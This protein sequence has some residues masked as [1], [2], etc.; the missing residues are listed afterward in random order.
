M[1]TIDIHEPDEIKRIFDLRN[2][3]YK[4]EPLDYG[5]YDLG[6]DVRVERKTLIDLQKSWLFDHNRLDNQLLN[7]LD[8]YPKSILLVEDCKLNFWVTK[9]GKRINPSYHMPTILKHV[10]HL[11]FKIPIVWSTNIYDTV[12][13]LI[14]LHKLALEDKHFI[15]KRPVTIPSIEAKDPHLL[16]LCGI[17]N[18]SEVKAKRILAKFDN[19]TDFLSECRQLQQFYNKPKH[20]R[21]EKKRFTQTNKLLQ[22]DGI[23]KKS[24]LQIA[25]FLL[26]GWQ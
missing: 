17:P 3:K 25:E 10:E 13:I 15:W 8:K 26:G 14:D 12:Q 9:H 4:V 11:N 6:N 7:M 1:I 16:F 24:A 21:G 18:I 2:A 5:D 22:I 19:L 20:K 23:S